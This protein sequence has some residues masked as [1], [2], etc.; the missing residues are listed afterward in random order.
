MKSILLLLCLSTSFISM[1][2]FDTEA[3][4]VTYMSGKDF[5]NSSNQ[6]TIS[7]EFLPTYNTY[8]IKCVNSS[9][10]K[11]YYINC[12]VR[13]YGSWASITGES[14]DG[15]GN[16]GFNVYSG[17]ISVEGVDFSIKN[18]SETNSSG[19]Y[20]KSVEEPCSCPTLSRGWPGSISSS[21]PTE[22]EKIKEFQNWMD[23]KHPGWVNGKSLKKGSGYGSWG[24]SSEEAWKKYCSEFKNCK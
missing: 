15:G 3:Q 7:Y 20:E 9:N 14:I 1:S 24:S 21:A 19:T 18:S 8:G 10:V 4:V 12:K 5:Y 11:F 16:F 13:I 23:T 22:I 6:M 17:K 2:Q